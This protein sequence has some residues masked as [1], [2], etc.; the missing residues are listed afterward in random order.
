MTNTVTKLGGPHYMGDIVVRFYEMD[1][2][3]YTTD[4]ESVAASVFGLTEVK[5]VFAMSTE[6]GYMYVWAR[7]TKKLLAL[8]AAATQATSTTDTGTVMLMVVGH[9]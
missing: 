9:P 2:T 7:S 5:E 8:T 6:N 4:G 3:S 1:I